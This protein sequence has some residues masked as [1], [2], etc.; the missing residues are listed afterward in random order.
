MG[1]ALYRF[2]WT[3]PPS[4]PVYM[5]IYSR[6]M[7]EY[8]G[9]GRSESAHVHVYNYRNINLFISRSASLCKDL[10]V[11]IGNALLRVCG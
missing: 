6:T 4:L 10:H 2:A 11:C 3:P 7:P 8:C 9:Q 5:S 1:I